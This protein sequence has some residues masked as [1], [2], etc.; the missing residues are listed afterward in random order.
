MHMP[1]TC[2]SVGGS[3]DAPHTSLGSCRLKMHPHNRTVQPPAQPR[4]VASLQLVPRLQLLLEL[5]QEKASLAAFLARKYGHES[6]LAREVASHTA[7]ASEVEPDV[8]CLGKK[9]RAE[10]DAEGREAAERARGVKNGA[11]APACTVLRAN[12]LPRCVGQRRVARR[13]LAS[14]THLARVLDA[15]AV[16][17]M[18]TK[19]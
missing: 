16:E 17:K 5:A 9:T 18:S 6:K 8:E 3:G 7:A 4:L 13:N 10:R 11:S 14:C 15:T 1:C 19:C 12:T 2:Q